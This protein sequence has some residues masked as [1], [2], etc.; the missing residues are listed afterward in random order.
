M[1]CGVELL[2]AHLHELGH[3]DA[4][5]LRDAN[6]QAYALI[7]GFE[8]PAGTFAGRKIDLAIQTQPD[9][10]RSMG[11]SIHIRAT[12]HLVP[13]GQALKNGVLIRNVIASGL[14]TDWQYW[15]Y[16]FTVHPANPALELLAQINGVFRQN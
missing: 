5:V 6:S 14:G 3:T 10:P 4:S 9:Y 8:I 15:S 12:P 1:N 16:R 11:S 7:P 2:V 13:F